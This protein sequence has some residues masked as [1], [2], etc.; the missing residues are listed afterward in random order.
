MEK[1]LVKKG[2][3]SLFL[4]WPE[5]KVRCLC[6]AAL[7]MGMTL[8]GTSAFSQDND[9]DSAWFQFTP[10]VD[11]FGPTI[12]D[13]SEFIEAPTGRHGFVTVKGENFIF[14]DGTPVRFWGSQTGAR[15]DNPEYSAKRMRRQGINLVRQHGN[16]SRPGQLDQLIARLGEQG[17]Y[18][19]I[20][21]Y[22]PLHYRWTPG[23]E[24]RGM[25]EGGTSQQVHFF[26]D[27]AAAIQIKR[28][29]DFFT[30]VNQANGKRW[31][32]DPTLAMIEI[33][34]EASMFW[35]E[36]D[37]SLRDQVQEKFAVWLLQKY[38]DQEGLQKA[39]SSNGVSGL[40]EGEGLREG[41]KIGLIRNSLFTEDYFNENPHKKIRGQDQMRF[42]LELEDNYWQACY[43]ALRDAGVKVPVCGTAWQGHGFPTRAHIFSQAKLDYI[44]RHGY[45]AHPQGEGNQMW[46][47]AT[48]TFN[49][50]PMIKSLHED[51]DRLIYLGHE[52]LVIEKAWEQVL[53][54]PLS[55]SEWSTVTPNWYSLEGTALMSIYG[56][57]QGWD[58]PLESNYQP[59]D[60][61]ERMGPNQFNLFGNPPHI[62]QFP[63]A[64][65]MWYRGDVK[66]AEVVAEVVH[67]AETI[68]E[69]TEDRK[70]LPL[71]AALIGKVGYRFVEDASA[72]TP[73]VKDISRYWDPETLTARSITG[74]LVWN[75]SAGVVVVNTA[76]TQAAVGFLDNGPQDLKDTKISSTTPFGALWVTA[77]DGEL[78][79]SS[80]RHILVTAVGPAKNTGMKYEMTGRKTRLGHPYARLTDMG[81][82]PILLEAVTGTV[83]IQNSN[84]SSMKAWALNVV[85]E[86][87]REVPLKK[88]PGRVILK[89]DP[90]YKTV[91]YEISVD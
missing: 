58:A 48:A 4:R 56:L 42:Y 6:I 33:L 37:E 78:P 74:E 46:S 22:Y 21:L 63:A 86:R 84:S 27:K 31:C 88:E 1:N 44:D 14:E 71:P 15:R 18:M 53:G 38:H 55:I 89:M 60:W 75:G 68:F 49:S 81:T 34:N 17:I 72:H 77:K 40:D 41:E 69:T 79:V 30:H 13:C 43:K 11:D 57:L 91:Y 82:P 25:P 67:D 51:Q 64:M 36:V 83:E 85:G 9:S 59:G 35:G 61:A 73:V 12:L 50:T 90:G 24:I 65:A 7:G 3:P 19:A 32:D 80:A 5:K 52:N 16:L 26:N 54:K 8:F 28:L 87:M 2:M 70:P 39:W 62:L 47:I 23:D 29:V 45:W 76:R 20:D 10:A 66:E